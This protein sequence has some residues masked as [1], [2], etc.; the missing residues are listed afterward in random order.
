MACVFMAVALAG[1]S[2]TFFIPLAKGSFSAP[3]VIYVHAVFVFGWLLLLILQ[4]SL[5]Q[6]RRLATHRQLGAAG[7]VVAL[8]VVVSGLWVGFH[9]TRRDL[10]RGGD[11]FV[12]GQLVNIHVEML[13][14]GALVAAAIHFRK[15]GEVHK[16]LMMLATISALAPAWLRFRHFMPFVP[17]PFVTFSLVADSLLLVV[18]ARDWRALGRVHPTYL[19]AGGAMVAVHVIE[20]LAIRSEPWLRLSRWLLEHSPV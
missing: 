7:A 4:A 12:L 19:W 17:D 11:D 1:F 13:L 8:G 15:Q 3:L 16:R 5:V 20:I 9:A 6:K 2:T 10:A 18:M 14:F